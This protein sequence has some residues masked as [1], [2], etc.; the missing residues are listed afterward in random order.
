M[1]HLSGSFL[2]RTAGLAPQNGGKTVMAATKIVK[3]AQKAAKSAVPRTYKKFDGE[4]GP[5]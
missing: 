3:K 1:A 2:G 5:Y 4:L